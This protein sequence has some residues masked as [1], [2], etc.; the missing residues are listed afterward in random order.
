M[1]DR[2]ELYKKLKPGYII[3]ICPFDLFE[4]GRTLL[5]LMSGDCRKL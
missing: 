3:F 4:K 1:I 5:T 2:G